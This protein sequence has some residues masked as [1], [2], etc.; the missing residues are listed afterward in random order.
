MNATQIFSPREYW[1]VTVNAAS[2]RKTYWAS[3]FSRKGN[4]FV[5]AV[6]D[7]AGSK[8]GKVVLGMGDDLVSV[9][10]AKLNLFFAT[11]QAS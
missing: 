3:D 2:G 5:F 6:V 10:D 1:R 4:R 7:R 11:M 9:Q 8:T